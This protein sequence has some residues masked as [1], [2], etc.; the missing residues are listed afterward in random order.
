[1]ETTA[2]LIALVAIA[3]P[4]PELEAMP[5]PL[6][7]LIDEMLLQP[8]RNTVEFPVVTKAYPSKPVVV[9]NALPTP[10]LDVMY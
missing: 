8:M 1:M 6:L 9:A 10:E 2:V 7:V 5:C 4:T 3:L